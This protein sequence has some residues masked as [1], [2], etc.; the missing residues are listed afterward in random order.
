LGYFTG[1][2]T[3]GFAFTSSSSS[4]SSFVTAFN[5]G[6]LICFTSDD[7]PPS[8]VGDH[9]YSVLSYDP[10]AQTVTLFNPW[11]IASGLT[12]LTWSQIQAN[13][14]YFDRTA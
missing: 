14:Q 2:A 3:V 1:Q 8:V 12:T 7:S 6:D 13:F 9:V 10:S 4:L 5:A 11:G